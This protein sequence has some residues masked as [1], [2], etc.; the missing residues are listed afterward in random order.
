[1][2]APVSGGSRARF[3]L[4]PAAA[5]T[6]FPTVMLDVTANLLCTAIILLVLSLAID[7]RGSEAASEEIAVVTAPT[8]MPAGLV[9][10]F[11]ARAGTVADSITIDVGGT[12]VTVKRVGSPPAAAVTLGRSDVAAGQLAPL[13][14]ESGQTSVLLFIFDQAGYGAVRRAIDKAGLPSWEIDVP[15][16]LRS[17]D[18]PQQWSQGFQSLFGLELDASAFQGRLRRILQGQ[19]GTDTAGADEG[20]GSSTREQGSLD[21]LLNMVGFWWRLTLVG[22]ALTFMIRLRRTPLGTRQQGAVE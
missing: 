16:A 18:G 2:P 8:L 13:L 3:G 5:D 14:T 19:G 10:A 1:M 9:A 20:A 22:A 12:G 17:A 4:V 15:L 6:A 7:R 11:R 21:R